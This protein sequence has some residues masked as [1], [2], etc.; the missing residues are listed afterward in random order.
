[1]YIIV[2]MEATQ[3]EIHR[4]NALL[5]FLNQHKLGMRIWRWILRVSQ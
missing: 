2:S 1:M 3:N 5:Y 4:M